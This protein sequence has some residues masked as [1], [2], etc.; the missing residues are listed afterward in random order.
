MPLRNRYR[1]IG[2][3]C[4]GVVAILLPS[5]ILTPAVGRAAY[6]YVD[7]S[8]PSLQ[9]IPIAV[10]VFH[11][12][13]GRPLEVAREASDLLASSLDF[14]GYFKIL[15]RSLFLVGPNQGGVT[16]EDVAFKDWTRI[17]AELLVTGLI[18]VEEGLVEM[19]LRLFDTVKGQLLVGKRYKGWPRDQK[20]MV[21]RFCNEIIHSLTGEWGYFDSRIAF[22]SNGTGHKEIYI[23]DFNGADPQQFTRHS[24]I[25]LFPAWSTDA[26]SLAYTCYARRGADIFIHPVSGRG[27]INVIS[28]TGINSTPAW[29]PGKQ[30][31]LAA[32]FSFTGDQE[33]YLISSDGAVV[34]KLT[35]QWGIDTSP[36]FSPDGKQMAF[37]SDRSG[38]PQIYIQDM[39]NGRARRLT[40]Q[41]GYNTQPRW[42]PRGDLIA[43]SSME[44]GEIN[45]YVI[46]PSGRR[47]RQLTRGAGKNE[48]PDWSPDGSMIVYSSNREGP[49]RIY[50]MTA[51]GTDQRRLLSLPGEQTS[52]RWSPRLS[53]N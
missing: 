32:T 33:I 3:I 15:D 12:P 37:V 25:A 45:I 14:T 7:I 47:P 22:I 48:S 35:D 11:T 19:E 43:Y 30:N 50:V 34:R 26:K 6:D 9:K 46:D 8:N 23:G 13:S 42:S 4:T 2:V 29:M 28:K 40:F 1:L 24:S 16:G 20:K 31:M 36:A 10:P 18:R 27:D 5:M 17:G 39:E 44:G 49:S 21:R 52:P 51:Y 53:R 41:G 38:S